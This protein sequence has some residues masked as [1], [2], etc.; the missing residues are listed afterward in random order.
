M[1]GLCHLRPKYTGREK[2]KLEIQLLFSFY[3]S[4]VPRGVSVSMRTMVSYFPGPR[5]PDNRR[6]T[7]AVQITV[8]GKTSPYTPRQPTPRNVSL[9]C[10][11]EMHE[12]VAGLSLPLTLSRFV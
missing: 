9:A 4:V 7:E 12:D 8:A 10:S 2:S 1:T 11:S 5:S 3:V 6:L